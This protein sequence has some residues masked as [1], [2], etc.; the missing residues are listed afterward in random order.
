[1]TKSI[2]QCFYTN[3]R[4]IRLLVPLTFMTWMR[5]PPRRNYKHFIASQTQFNLIDVN[6]SIQLLISRGDME[7]TREAHWQACKNTICLWSTATEILPHWYAYFQS[8]F[9]SICPPATQGVNS[10]GNTHFPSFHCCR[11]CRLKARNA[12]DKTFHVVLRHY[13]RGKLA[14]LLPRY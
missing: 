13:H 14:S 7:T 2:L 6:T 12:S 8:T 3:E 10:D 11:H 4:Y 9:A 5:K 1:M